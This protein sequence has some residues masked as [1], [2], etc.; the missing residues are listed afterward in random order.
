MTGARKSR[1]GAAQG[2][3]E[4]LPSGRCWLA[5]DAQQGRKLMRQFLVVASL[6][7]GLALTGCDDGTPRRGEPYKAPSATEQAREV[8]GETDPAELPANQRAALVYA[9][10]V[11]ALALAR[12]GEVEAAQT[13][14]GM[15][16][17]G[18]DA[19]PGLM[20]GLDTLGFDPAPLEAALAAPQDETVA[21]AAD[22]MLDALRQS[23]TGDVKGTTEFLMKSHAGAYG[24]S[25]SSREIPELARSEE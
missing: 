18:A 10:A 9:R 5:S 12:A 6:G 15:I 19:E 11:T 25:V 22:T 16:G 2:P 21:E 1:T 4:G 23:A 17:I 7:L 13:Q 20:V 14:A 3:A 24:G 8:F